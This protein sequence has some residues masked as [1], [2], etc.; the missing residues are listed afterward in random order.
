MERE[1]ECGHKSVMECFVDPSK[2]RCRVP[3]KCLLPCEHRVEIDCGEDPTEARCPLPCD[4]RL[5]CG[6]TCTR[7]CHLKTDPDHEEYLCKK[8]CGRMRKGCKKDHKCGKKC[9]EE[10]D[11]CSEKWKRNLPCGHSIFIECYL[12]DEDIFCS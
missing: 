6:H 11:D 3:K 4:V 8:D 7:K 10:C 12:N 2:T 5:E 1:F 9:F